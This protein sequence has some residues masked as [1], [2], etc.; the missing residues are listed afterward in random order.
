MTL[1]QET[2][3]R[4]QIIKNKALSIPQVLVGELDYDHS[5]VYLD[6]PCPL[7]QT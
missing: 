4:I 2:Y 3:L 7:Y 1:I 5:V 6:I